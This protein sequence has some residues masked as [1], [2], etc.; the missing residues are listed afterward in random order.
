MKHEYPILLFCIFEIIILNKKNFKIQFFKFS[1]FSKFQ[2]FE[3]Q[4]LNTTLYLIVILS[5]TELYF[6]LLDN[7]G[8]KLY[9][10]LLDY[11]GYT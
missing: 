11:T 7:T 1:K 9:F 4:I 10:V 6:V 5:C 2:I 3:F 8:I